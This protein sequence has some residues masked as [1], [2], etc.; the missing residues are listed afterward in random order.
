LLTRDLGLIIL[1]EELCVN[2]REE[3][4][5]IKSDSL[6]AYWDTL[7]NKIIKIADSLVTV[8]PFVNNTYCI[9]QN[10]ALMTRKKNLRRR[11][12]KTKSL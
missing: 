6:Q 5:D 9:Q 8:K 2:I 7:E 12:L 1:A 4:W 11:L 3:D 10:S